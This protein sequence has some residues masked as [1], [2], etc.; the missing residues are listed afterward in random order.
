MNTYSMSKKVFDSIR[1]R[2]WTVRDTIEH[3]HEHAGIKFSKFDEKYA[4][5]DI[6]DSKKL[7]MFLLKEG[8]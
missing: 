1:Q 7:L 3:I 8:C 2:N 6:V 5:F 4:Y